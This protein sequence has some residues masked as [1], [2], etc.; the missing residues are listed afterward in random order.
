MCSWESLVSLWSIGPD[1]EEKA[2]EKT[3]EAATPK[4]NF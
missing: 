3:I 1:G 2:H 4:G